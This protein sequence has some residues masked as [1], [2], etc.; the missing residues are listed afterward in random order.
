MQLRLHTGGL[1]SLQGLQGDGG[2]KIEG[3]GSESQCAGAMQGDHS[4]QGQF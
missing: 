3:Y 2:C 1:R 4:A